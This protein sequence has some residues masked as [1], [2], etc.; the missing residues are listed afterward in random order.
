MYWKFQIGNA[1]IDDVTGTKGIVDYLWTHA[2]N[3]DQTHELI[4]KYCDYSSENISQICSNATRRA[5]TEKG[6]IDFYNIY[7]PLCHDSSLKNESSSGC[8]SK[9]PISWCALLLH[10]GKNNS[11]FN[12]DMK[13]TCP[14]L[15]FYP[16]SLLHLFLFSFLCY[17]SAYIL[18][19]GSNWC[20]I[21]E[22]ISNSH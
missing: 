10:K 20:N 12:K 1:W 9:T 14:V 22:A 11:K 7:A 17:N 15:P 21:L 5:L 4:E 19:F 13:F 2:L 16:L 18:F 6:N 8:V 3:S